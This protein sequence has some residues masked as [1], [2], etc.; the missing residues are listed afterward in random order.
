MID[1]V[2]F[3][4]YLSLNDIVTLKSG[5]RVMRGHWKWYHSKAWVRFLIHLP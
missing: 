1:L 5:L 4:S 3:S 2:P